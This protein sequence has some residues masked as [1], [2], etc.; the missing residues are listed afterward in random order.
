MAHKKILTLLS[1]SGG[2][3]V[4]AAAILLIGS[5]TPAQVAHAANG[6]CVW[7]GGSGAP[8]H[9]Y[10]KAEDCKGKGG[11]AICSAAVGN[12]TA[13][14]GP[15]GWTYQACD[16]AP[17]ATWRDRA[18]CEAAGGEWVINGGSAS[19]QSLPGGV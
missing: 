8:L 12:A 9:A 19:C 17:P 4:L 18:W 3:L 14:T 1:F 11:E 10:C 2:V 7:E 15:D 13:V 16:E 5:F 6:Q